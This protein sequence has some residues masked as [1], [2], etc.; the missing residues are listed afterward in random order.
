MKTLTKTQIS[1]IKAMA[2]QH[3]N[4]AGLR[5]AR[6]NFHTIKQVLDNNPD[7][8]LW[9]LDMV[10]QLLQT[11]V[12]GCGDAT[13]RTCSVLRR[14]YFK[15]IEGEE[16]EYEDYQF[17][18]PCFFKNFCSGNLN[19]RVEDGWH[20]NMMLLRNHLMAATSKDDLDKDYILERLAKIQASDDL[21]DLH[22]YVENWGTE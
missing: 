9:T 12:T 14:A 10:R 4:K 22:D 15:E 5:V 6:D 2:R 1:N 17:C 18:V 3:L 20:W 19:N 8:D 13:H 16:D 7:V 11:F 21:Q